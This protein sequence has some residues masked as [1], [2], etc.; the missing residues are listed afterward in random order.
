MDI[1]NTKKFLKTSEIDDHYWKKSWF[2]LGLLL[3]ALEKDSEIEILKALNNP[4][5]FGGRT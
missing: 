5:L 4:N 3:S 2:T 1:Y